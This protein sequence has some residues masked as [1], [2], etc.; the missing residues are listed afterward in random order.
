MKIVLKIWNAIV[1]GK[2]VDRTTNIKEKY[3]I[4]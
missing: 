1:I 3:V 2:I 4:D